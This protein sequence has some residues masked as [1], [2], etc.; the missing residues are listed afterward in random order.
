[1][2]ILCVVFAGLTGW[3]A[4]LQ[5]NDKPQYGTEAWYLWVVFYGAVAAISL[6]S[7]FRPLPR[8]FLGLGALGCL[9]AAGIRASNIE[10]DKT[11][12][13]N[14]SNPAGNE[15]GGLLICAL[16]LGLL[17]WRRAATREAH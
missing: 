13:Y 12:L 8:P 15:A 16:W 14:E 17:A 1:M 2:R 11:V 5:F 10:W 9:V 7:A 4:Q 3:A 6:V